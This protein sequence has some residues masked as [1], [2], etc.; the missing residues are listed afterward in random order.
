MK[1]LVQPLIPL[2]CET[3]ASMDDAGMAELASLNIPERE[4]KGAIPFAADLRWWFCE[5]HHDGTLLEEMADV[6]LPKIFPAGIRKP[7]PPV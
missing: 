2:L 6:D 5:K 4:R 1:R 3:G 7:E